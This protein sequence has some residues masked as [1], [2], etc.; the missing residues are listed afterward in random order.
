M[1]QKILV[2]GTS[3]GFGSLITKTLLKDG[4]TVVATMRGSEGKNK[5]AAEELKELGAHIVEID[6]TDDA[7][8]T[9]GVTKAVE[10]AGGLDVVVNNAGVGVLGW[11]EHFTP[12]DWQKLFDINVFGVQRM[13]R[14]VLPHFHQQGSGLLLHISSL[15]GRMV[16]PTYGPYNAS[17]W[18]VEAMAENYRYELAPFGIDSVVVEPGGFP[19]GFFDSLMRPSDAARAESY[20][21]MANFPE[22]F[23]KGFEAN[24][25]THEAQSP[26]LVAD[27]VSKLVTTPAGERP[28][29]T[30]VDTIGMSAAIEPLNEASTTITK[31]LFTAFG[32]TDFLTLKK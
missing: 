15:L 18:A 32:L 14:A 28:F 16:V 30:T 8:V 24:L 21:E 17:K 23:F 6:V 4:H 20:G 13:N 25:A 26:Q 29:R 10:L 11:Q 19:T 3:S 12:E 22:E 5:E 2:T 7:S 1:S 9:D 31:N 27:A